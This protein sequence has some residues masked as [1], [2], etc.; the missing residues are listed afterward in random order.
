MVYVRKGKRTMRKRL[1]KTTRRFNLT[2]R[3]TGRSGFLKVLRWSSKDTSNQCHLTIAGSDVVQTTEGATTF[4]LYDVN[5]Q[6]ELVSLFDNYRMVKVL[7]RWVIT[8]NPSDN[9]TAGYKGYYPRITWVHDF[10]SSASINRGQMYQHANLREVFMGDN[11]QK[12]K[13]YTLSPA[14]L[15]QLYEGPTTTS[16]APKWRQW[17][18]TQDNQCPHYGI[19]YV[20]DNLTSTITLRLEAKLVFECKGIS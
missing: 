20:V 6:A 12:T 17:M 16:Y 2:K 19:K 11:Y 8:R 14:S 13:W 7:Y 4:A 18:D 10:N 9:P 5:G 3:K 15:T 1:R